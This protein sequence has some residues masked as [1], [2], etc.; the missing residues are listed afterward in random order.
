MAV[1]PVKRFIA[2]PPTGQQRTSYWQFQ[3]LQD[4][5]GQMQDTIEALEAR[6]EDLEGKVP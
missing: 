3:Q 6:I 5:L 2:S 1:V 4:I